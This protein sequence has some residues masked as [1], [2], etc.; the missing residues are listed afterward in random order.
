M[1]NQE[2]QDRRNQ[3]NESNEPFESDA[4]KLAQEHLADPNHVITDEALRNIKVGVTPAVPDKPTEEAIE[5][6]E[7]KIADHKADSEDDTIPGGQKMT[8]WD[9]IT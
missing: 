5:D 9:T 8:P 4:H 7:D 6:A 2:N 3:M 1:S